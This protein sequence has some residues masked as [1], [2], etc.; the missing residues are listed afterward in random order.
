MIEIIVTGTIRCYRG[1]RIHFLG[2]IVHHPNTEKQLQIS[3]C[4]DAE[5]PTSK[6]LVIFRQPLQ[7]D[8]SQTG[9]K[10]RNSM[11]GHWLSMKSY[12]L[13]ATLKLHLRAVLGKS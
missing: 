6:G 12:I 2:Q 4:K 8:W 7:R 10:D 13:S 3:C 9:L 5:K 1:R 11:R